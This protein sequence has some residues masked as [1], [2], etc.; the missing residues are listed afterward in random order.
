MYRTGDSDFS[1]PKLIPKFEKEQLDDGT[2][3]LL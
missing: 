2:E 3:G 1:V